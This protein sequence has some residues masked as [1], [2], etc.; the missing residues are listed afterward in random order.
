MGI[1]CIVAPSEAEAQCAELAR[2]GKVYA[3]GS[4]DMDTLTFSAPILFRH[5]TF[6]EAKKQPISEINLQAALDGLEMDMSQFIDLCLLLGCDYL[7][8]IKGIGPKTA[9][10][11]IREYKNLK[12]VIAHLREKEAEKAAAAK[13]EEE[14]DDEPAPTSDVEQPDHSEGEDE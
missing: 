4:E 7:E 3:A 1:P 8:P 2:G 6:S 10:K 14:S 5:L 12:G 11:L 13:P 9:L